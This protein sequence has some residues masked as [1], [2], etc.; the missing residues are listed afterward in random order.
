MNEYKQQIIDFYDD[1]DNYDNDFTIARAINLCNLVNLDAVESV[2]D[3]A[4]GTGI[5][6]I[7]VA[8]KLANNPTAKVVGIDF[9]PKM[10]DRSRE[11]IAKLG[12]ENIELQLVDVDRLDYPPESFD[13]IFCSSAIV[14]F[15]DVI[16]VLKQWHDW[17]KPNGCI[18]FSVYS[19][20]SFFTPTIMKVTKELGYD[21]PNFHLL[22]GSQEKCENV[23]NQLGFEIDKFEKQQ[24]GKYL[25][26]EDAQKWWHGN[27]LHPTFHPLLKISEQER[28]RLKG[29]FAQEMLNF[30]TEK[31]VWWENEIFYVVASKK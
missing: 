13:V 7:A 9:S 6:A 1:R 29:K 26:L 30:N 21:L 5:V 31:G 2:L 23:L 4:T 24:L 16:N 25:T 12:L 3:V 11:K 22:L 10:L 20:Q 8:Q 14:L 28:N 27:W 17:L 18:A 19:E 15:S